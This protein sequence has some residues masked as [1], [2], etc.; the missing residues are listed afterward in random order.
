MIFMEYESLRR[1]LEESRETL[2][3]VLNKTQRLFERTQPSGVRFDKVNVQGG[4]G[5]ADNWTEYVQEVQR[6]GLDEQAR[7][8]KRLIDLRR[9]LLADK[10]R[11]LYESRDDLDVVYR[12]LWIERRDVA[13]IVKRRLVYMSPAGVYRRKKEIEQA[14]G[15]QN[16][17]KV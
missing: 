13:E 17:G 5:A 16:N 11:E 3:R 1:E 10:R 9:E 7:E 4:A 12:L 8:A 6:L 2:R 15:G 14:I